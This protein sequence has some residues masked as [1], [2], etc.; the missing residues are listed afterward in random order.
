MIGM[1]F[2]EFLNS[3]F[4]EWNQLIRLL[5]YKIS[6]EELIQADL[7]YTKYFLIHKY[8]IQFYY[9]QDYKKILFNIK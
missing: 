7:E 9:N 3:D 1:K 8:N 2:E 4:I 6:K 5:I